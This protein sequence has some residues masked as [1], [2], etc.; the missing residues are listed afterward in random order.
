MWN[1]LPQ[2]WVSTDYCRMFCA[3]CEVWPKNN[4]EDDTVAICSMIWV[5]AAVFFVSY[6]KY[7]CDTLCIIFVALC[8]KVNI[9]EKMTNKGSVCMAEKTPTELYRCSIPDDVKTKDL[10]FKALDDKLTVIKPK[11]LDEDEITVVGYV[12]VEQDEYDGDQECCIYLGKGDDKKP[13]DVYRKSKLKVVGYLPVEGED[14]YIAVVK[15]RN[16]FLL[17]LLGVGIIAVLAMLMVFAFGHK[18]T[19][20]D[21]STNSKPEITIASGE[22]FDGNI[23]N[24]Q[25]TPEEAEMKYIEV[26][27]YSE[28]YVTP[29]T[30]VDLA[31]PESNNVYFK[32]TIT[33]DDTVLYE[34]DYIKPGEKIDWNAAQN[35]IGSGEHSLIFAITTLSVGTQEPCNGATFA[36]TAHVS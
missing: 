28:I 35:I 24:G 36:V 14:T 21:D 3:C 25:A 13:F 5:V 29:G 8:C 6:H 23:D 12:D 9:L 22:P 2:L 26:P 16:L 18:D 30:T 7:V 34:T 11:E 20:S 1:G 31:N 10:S 32:Y 17:I 27:G 4:Q 33:E 19:S 15:P